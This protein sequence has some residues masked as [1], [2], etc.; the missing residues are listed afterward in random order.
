MLTNI[1]PRRSQLKSR[2]RHLLLLIYNFKYDGF[3]VSWLNIDI[4]TNFRFSAGSYKIFPYSFSNGTRK[5]FHRSWIL[6]I[7]GRFT[8][9]PQL[10]QLHPGHFAWNA[11]GQIFT[12]FWS[13]YSQPVVKIRIR[14]ASTVQSSS[15]TASVCRKWGCREFAVISLFFEKELNYACYYKHAENTTPSCAKSATTLRRVP[16]GNNRAAKRLIF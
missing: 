7:T 5:Q 1:R 13:R 9:Q 4:F 14:M 12:T 2:F 8:I 3:R 6:Q 16:T 15:I 10:L 11:L